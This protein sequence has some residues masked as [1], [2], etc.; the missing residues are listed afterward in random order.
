MMTAHAH[1]KAKIDRRGLSTAFLFC[2]HNIDYGSQPKSLC[3]ETTP[4]QSGWSLLIVSEADSTMYYLGDENLK[5]CVYSTNTTRQKFDMA[6]QD[7]DLFVNMQRN[8]RPQPRLPQPRL[9]YRC[10]LRSYSSGS[11]VL[12]LKGV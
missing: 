11:T 6:N 10:P 7:N 8:Q 4:R 5:R 12:L 3:N 9:L 2:P 1:R